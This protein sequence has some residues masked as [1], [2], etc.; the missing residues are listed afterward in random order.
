MRP[1]REESVQQGVFALV[2]L[3]DEI[4]VAEP[5]QVVGTALDRPAERDQL[6]PQLSS[7]TGR[8][9]A[10]TIVVQRRHERVV[11]VHQRQ[12]AFA[13]RRTEAALIDRRVEQDAPFAAGRGRA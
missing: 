8:L 4:A 1:H 5:C 9:L 13:V 6:A 10:T 7:V 12:P 2:L 3:G 11:R